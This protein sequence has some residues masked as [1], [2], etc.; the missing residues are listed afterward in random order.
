M[1]LKEYKA[2]RD[3]KKTSEPQGKRHAKHQ[4]IYVVQKHDASHLHYDFRLAINGVLKS[5]SIP[6]GPCLDPT[7]KR[8]AVETEDHPLEYADFEGVIPQQEY[9]GGTVMVWDYGH[10]QAENE[11]PEKA[12][13]DGKITFTLKGK[14]LTGEWILLRTN[15]RPSKAQ[16]LLI[17]KKDEQSK[18]LQS[19]DI[20]QQ[21]PNSAVTDR[22]LDEIVQKTR[23]N[24]SLNK[25]PTA[26]QQNKGLPKKFKPQLATLV[27]QVPKSGHWIYELKLDGYRLLSYIK[28]KKISLITRSGQDWTAKFPSI[29]NELQQMK[30]KD[31]ILDGEIVALD[32]KGRCNFQLLQNAIKQSTQ[33]NI[34]Y[35]IFDIP[36]YDKKNLVNLPLIERKSLLQQVLA[37]SQASARVHYCEHYQGEGEEFLKEVCEHKL[38]G[39]IAKRANSNYQQARSKDWLKIKCWQRQ[40]FV[41]VG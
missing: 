27:K 24:F 16:W 20:T 35:Y 5:W 36:F 21:Q 28:G 38:E 9:G 7:I 3:F 22:S 8:L 19:Y 33:K 31:G 39:L 32:S 17:K 1:S 23:Q 34:H 4:A 40:E 13:N 12:Y 14:K 10:W 6:K 25:K 30:L 15:R 41:I 2:K 37:D 11:E 26:P 29:V 18:T